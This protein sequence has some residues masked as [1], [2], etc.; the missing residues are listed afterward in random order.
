M[1]IQ[2]KR[3][4]GLDL[5]RASAISLVVISHCTFLLFPTYNHS[6]I[7]LI[8]VLGAV[9]V[10]LF[11]VLSGFLIG[12]ILLKY[13]ENEKT[14][15]SD[16]INFWKRRWIRTLPNYFFILLINIF[17]FFI[18]GEKLP[19]DIGQYFIFI[20]NFNNPH[21]DFFTEA[22]SLSIEEYAYLFLPLLF[23]IGFL[24]FKNS[25]KE[26]IF[27]W[28]SIISI[29]ILCL[30]KIKYFLNA[31]VESYKT[32]SVTFRKVV[33]YRIDAIYFGFLVVYFFRK[34]HEFFERNRK[35]I[36]FVGMILFMMVHTI[37]FTFQI[38]PQTHLWF[39]IFVYLQL[40]IVSLGLLFPYFIAINYNGVFKK[41]IEFISTRSYA[42]YLINYSLILLGIQRCFKLNEF[43]FYQKL[44]LVIFF[45]VITLLLSE[46]LYKFFEKPILQY[47]NRK[48]PS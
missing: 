20:Q 7:T 43:P 37:I 28:F 32:W 11:F 1:H 40:V 19:K 29:F 48:F 45:L 6:I 34:Y 8:R 31:E 22:W 38:L 23:Y 10:D 15:F 44:I 41:S 21:P 24:L 3:N 26:K 36:A 16:L 14:G 4:F 42:I 33:L 39:Y 13:I 46:M 9:G 18:I 2:S 25:N 35:L 17:L 27:L 12:G 5:I 30:L 47:R